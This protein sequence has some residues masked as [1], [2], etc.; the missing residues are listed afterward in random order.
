M[1]RRRSIAPPLLIAAIGLAQAAG[2]AAGQPA[3]AAEA[4]FQEGRALLMAGKTAEACPKL[5]ESQRLDP[6][7]GTLLALAL[8]HEQQDKLASAWAAFAD[9][10]ARSRLDGRADRERTARDHGAALRPRLSTLTL[11]VPADERDTKA[12]VISIDGV[13]IRRP[14]W[15]AALP[16]DGG[17]HVVEAVVPGRTPWKASVSVKSERDHVRLLVLLPTALV[18]PGVS[19]PAVV[20]AP[21]THSVGARR[22]IGLAVAGAGVIGLGASVLLG[23]DARSDYRSAIAMCQ[24]D[25]CATPEPYGRVQAAQDQGDLAT[26]L[27]IGGGAAAATGAALWFWPSASADSPT[28]AAGPQLGV[29]RGGLA[30]SGR[31]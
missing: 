1:S 30:V 22:V 5:E 9:I 19:R 28:A 2:G 13:P 25:G 18:D 29:S 17:D 8:C 15:N 23:L 27:A 14:A 26:L 16:I 3:A 24:G 31:F 7:T 11:V 4:L 21:P 6:A 10:E 12:L 20:G